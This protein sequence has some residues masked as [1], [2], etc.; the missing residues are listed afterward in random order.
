MK[1]REARLVQLDQQRQAVEAQVALS[2]VGDV[3]KV[4][5]ELQA[6]AA[7][8]RSLLGQQPVHARTILAKLV[9]GRVTFTPGAKERQWELR[10]RGTIAG[11][12]EA[13]F[14]LGM[15]SPTGPDRLQ[16]PIDRWF[17]ADQPSR[18]A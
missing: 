9:V 18:A 5:C 14:P 2:D 4:R 3:D 13:V 16:T 17:A 6:L 12:F 11:L 8:W 1:E 10:G 7:D 15:A